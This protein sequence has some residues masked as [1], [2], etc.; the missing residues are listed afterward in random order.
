LGN[1]P[2]IAVVGL[3]LVVGLPVYLGMWALMPGG[4]QILRDLSGYITLILIK[5][6]F[7]A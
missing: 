2:D 4:M 1:Q 5:K 7:E 6:P 3:S